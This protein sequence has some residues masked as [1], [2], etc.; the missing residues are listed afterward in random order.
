ME[1]VAEFSGI[2]KRA[3]P[4]IESLSPETKVLDIVVPFEDALKLNIAIDEC[5][6]KLNRY[7]RGK[8]EGKKAA[9]QLNIYLDKRRVMVLEGSTR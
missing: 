8:V 1:R 3:I 7:D 6:R 2:R 9:L 4:R 5:V